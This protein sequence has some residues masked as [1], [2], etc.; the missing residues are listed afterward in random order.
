MEDC[1]YGALEAGWDE[2]WVSFFVLCSFCLLNHKKKKEGSGWGFFFL[3]AVVVVF[4]IGN[5]MLMLMADDDVLHVRT[6][7]YGGRTGL[8]IYKDN[9]QLLY[10]DNNGYWCQSLYYIVS[11]E[12]LVFIIVCTDHILVARL[13]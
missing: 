13:G 8:A 11:V 1:G 3:P 7:T 4:G 9:G 6:A 2:S 5:D 12:F 10:V